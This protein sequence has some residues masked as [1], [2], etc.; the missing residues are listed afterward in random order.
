VYQNRSKLPYCWKAH[1]TQTP[2]VPRTSSR[3]PYALGEWSV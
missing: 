2:H 1:L 3:G